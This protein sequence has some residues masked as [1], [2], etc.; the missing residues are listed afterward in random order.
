MATDTEEA[1]LARRLDIPRLLVFIAVC[2]EGSITGA[3]R[4]LHLAQPAVTVAIAKLERL[5]DAHLLN[6]SLRGVT[7]TDSGKALL[8]RAYEITGLARAAVEEISGIA[9][10]PAGE[11]TVGLPSSSAAVL[12]LPLIDRLSQRYPQIRLRLVDSFSGYL[13]QWLEVDELDVA[14]VFDRSSTAFVECVPM[15]Q[16]DLHL[17]GRPELLSSSAGIS[18]KKAASFSLALASRKHGIRAALE[19]HFVRHGVP[20]TVALD[21]DAGQHL[22]RLIKS[23]DWCSLLAPCAVAEELARGELVARRLT[24]AFSRTVCLARRKASRGNSAVDVVIQELRD[25]S[26]S[27]ISEGVWAAR[28]HG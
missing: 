25:L 12:A 6:R 22:V 8:S 24:P 26:R 3:A 16:E 13:W 17:V 18:L 27:L 28:W 9:R 4:R 11:V 1:R 2:E 14:L 21:I 7:L 15:A 23:S 20:L 10:V 5:L 19:D